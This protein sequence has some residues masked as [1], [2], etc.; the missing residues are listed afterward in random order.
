M[1]VLK[2]LFTACYL[3]GIIFQVPL[4]SMPRS[5]QETEE[6]VRVPISPLESSGE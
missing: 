5:S 6:E 4:L 2:S 3:V 1:F